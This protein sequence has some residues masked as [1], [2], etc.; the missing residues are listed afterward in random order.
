MNTGTRTISDEKLQLVTGQILIG[1][2]ILLSHKLG[3]F[4]L[5]SDHPKST[6][7]ELARL[8]EL[9]HRATQSL[10]S[11]AASLDLI[12]CDHGKYYL[13][14]IGVKFFNRDSDNYYG[15]VFD[16][17]IEQAEIMNF[18]SIE[19]AI[20]TNSSQADSGHDVF[21]NAQGLGNTEHFVSALHHKAYAPAFYWPTL[22]DLSSSKKII[23]IGGGS[24]IHAIAATIL[25][26]HIK[27]LVCDRSP[28]LKYT[29]E[30]IN[31]F[32]L[33]DR[34][35]VCEIDLWNDEK[36]PEGD[37][38]FL[39]DIFHDWDFHKCKILSNKC[40]ESLDSGGLIIVHEMLF[41]EEKTG[42]L[43]TAAYNL[44]MMLW[45]EGRQYT[46]SELKNI[47][48]SAGFCNIEQLQSLGN[49][50]VIIGKKP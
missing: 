11:A 9:S 30:Y 5:L 19:K 28:V 45:T 46:F 17:L 34:I 37:I 24:G 33:D 38:F 35:K 40:F 16:L 49:W 14:P 1:Q 4:Q 12:D 23:D 25:N 42:P 7:D 36:F 43:L 13:S 32:H 15:N 20:R 41:N 2:A 3:L 48:E 31:K 27:A 8:L 39:G 44:K 6:V 18:K 22:L 47:L 21:S 10:I 26:P 50:S 29:K